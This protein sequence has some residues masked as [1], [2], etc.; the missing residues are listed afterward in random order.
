[1]TAGTPIP[2]SEKATAPGWQSGPLIGCI[3]TLAAGAVVLVFLRTLHPVFWT[4]E[5]RDDVGLYLP[6]VQWRLDR[7]NSML[8]VGLLGALTAAALAIGEGIVRRSRIAQIWKARR[9]DR[10]AIGEGIVRRWW[11]Q[12]LKTAAT[13]AAVSLLIGGLGGYLGHRMFEYLKSQ[14]DL[15]ELIKTTLVSGT[16]LAVTGGGVGLATGKFLE[17][18]TAAAIRGALGGLLAGLLA[19]IIYPLIVAALLPNAM[20]SVLL[21][22]EI[23]ERVLWLGLATGLQGLIIPT[24][25]RR[26]ARLSK[27]NPSST[28]GT[29]LSG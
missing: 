9:A 7:N 12:T 10:L 16:M 26:S 2:P 22:L 11:S 5:G 8:L 13:C 4:N 25:V 28:Q 17:G 15:D 18:S 29:H 27:A 24:V 23:S 1:M 6:D 3:S 21:P 14:R 19:S 20:T